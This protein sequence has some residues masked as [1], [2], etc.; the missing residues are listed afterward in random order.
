MLAL[1]RNAIGAACADG[2]ASGLFLIFIRGWSWLTLSL[3][4][5]QGAFGEDLSE[6]GKRT[7]A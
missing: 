1:S 6:E 7:K 3:T 5:R 4:S 2:V